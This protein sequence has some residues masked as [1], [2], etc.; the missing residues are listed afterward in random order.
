M[1]NGL[2]PYRDLFEQKGPLLFLI[3]GI[4]YI[5]SNTTYIG[6][7][8]LQ[9]LS[10]SITLIFAYKLLCLYISK[11]RAKLGTI[12]LPLF[13]YYGTSYC[14]GGNTAEEYCLPFMMISLYYFMLYF[15]NTED[16][17]HK[18]LIMLIH[19]FNAAC[20]F[21]IKFNLSAFWFGFGFIIL[22]KLIA[23]KEFKNLFINVFYGLIGFSIPVIPF[24]IYFINANGLK[25][26][27]SM[28][29][30]LNFKYAEDMSVSPNKFHF[31]NIFFFTI[32]KIIV[33]HPFLVAA[34]TISIISVS[35]DN[36]IL[37]KYGQKAIILSVVIF[38]LAIYGSGHS[39]KYYIIPFSIFTIF[40]IL[41][42]IQKLDKVLPA[43]PTS[44][45]IIAIFIATVFSNYIFVY[46]SHLI[47][48]GKRILAQYAFAEI[49]NKEAK[50][51]LLE[52]TEPGATYSDGFLTAANLLP[53]TKYFSTPN[54]PYEK[55]PYP[56]EAQ[57]EL[58]KNKKIKFVIVMEKLKR[59]KEEFNQPPMGNL[60]IHYEIQEALLNNYKPI[61][62]IIQKNGAGEH[63]YTLYKLK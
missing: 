7:Y 49:I 43:R 38:Y 35:R 53:A 15:K 26:A 47:R 54:L 3:N 19:G 32:G 63:I 50:P 42:V 8:L 36:N 41:Y 14:G 20:V 48:N 5:I 10:L 11:E 29:L 24:I 56:L 57:L 61:Q 27:I 55:F 62:S 39:S 17:K 25:D 28:Y 23:A 9:C 22:I 12:I 16:N 40:G 33:V 30:L 6:I 59:T 46:H 44:L 1:M 58:I 2:V 37:S 31:I 18:P 60:P 21:L 52:L 4:G 13:I 45:L 34:I 51:T